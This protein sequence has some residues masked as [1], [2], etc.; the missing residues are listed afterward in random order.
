MV[1]A[2]GVEPLSETPSALASTRLADGLEFQRTRPIGSVVSPRN[3][4]DL[5]REPGYPTLNPAC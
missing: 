3:L 4:F 5:S 1:E 2:R